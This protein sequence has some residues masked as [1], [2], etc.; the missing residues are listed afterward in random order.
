M[1]EKRGHPAYF[2]RMLP[3]LDAGQEVSVPDI[4]P[5]D[6][7]RDVVADRY[8]DRLGLLPSGYAERIIRFYTLVVGVRLDVRRMAAGEFKDKPSAMAALIREDLKVW[9][10]ARQLGQELAVELHKVAEPF[11]SSLS[12]RCIG[13]RKKFHHYIRDL[14]MAPRGQGA[15]HVYL[16]VPTR[17]DGRP[18]AQSS[19]IFDANYLRLSATADARCLRLNARFVRRTRNHP[20]SAHSM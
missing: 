2:E 14:L 9:R 8:I 13:T 11:R 16:S 19:A 6:D 5:G 3:K 7:Q 18:D 10:E 20:G 12:S 15:Q 17:N 1:T 4:M